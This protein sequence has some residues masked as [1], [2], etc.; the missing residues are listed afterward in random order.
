MKFIDKNNHNVNLYVGQFSDSIEHVL[1]IP[2]YKKQYLLTHHSLR[3][4]EFPGGKIEPGESMEEAAKRELFEETGGH[5]NR[6]D[7]IG[8]YRVDSDPE[9]VK[10][11]FFAEVLSLENQD[12][13]LETQGPV[14]VSHLNE[15]KEKL[16]SPLLLDQCVQYLYE[17]SKSHEFFK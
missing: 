13:Y 15:L 10:A 2:K 16:K 6:L 5:I 7:Y 3:G 11:V 14:F 9:I 1:I 4:I 12:D 17:M 8:F